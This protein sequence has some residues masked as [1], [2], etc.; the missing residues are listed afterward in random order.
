MSGIINGEASIAAGDAINY[1]NRGMEQLGNVLY[2][3]EHAKEAVLASLVLGSDLILS[4]LP[5]GGKST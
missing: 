3:E 2:G 5:G 1:H 4:G